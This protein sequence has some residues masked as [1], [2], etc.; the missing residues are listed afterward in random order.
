MRFQRI[1][2][3]SF[4]ALLFTA[5]LS[6][7]GRAETIY[8][9]QTTSSNGDT[10]TG[11]VRF[12]SA[13]PGTITT[14]GPMTTGLVAGHTVRSIDFRP[15]NGL[16]YA[17]SSNGTACQLYSVSTTTSQLF[18]IGGGFTLPFADPNNRVEIDFN[19]VID[20]IRLLTAANLDGSSNPVVNNFTLNPNTGVLTNQTPLNYVPGD[21]NAGL[22]NMELAAAAYTNP[23]SGTTTL[24]GWDWS[25]DSIV[26]IGSIGGTPDSP[27]TGRMTTVRNGGFLTNGR[28]IG[29]DYGP[30]GTLYITKDNAANTNMGLYTYVPETGLG[31]NPVLVGNYGIFISDISV[32]RPPTAA[33]VTLSGRV[34]QGPEGRGIANV[35]VTITGPN[36]F[37]S[38]TTTGKGGRYSF[39]DLETG[40]SYVISIRSRNYN[41]SPRVVQ[42][43]DNISDVD[44][45]VG[46]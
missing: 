8:G 42:V 39:E 30:S 32:Q 43:V 24:Y 38:T 14:I 5:V 35:F 6:I 4:G 31:V 36:G 23:S 34:A 29:M 22:A 21:P 15:S 33:G 45:F 11:L 28:G 1:L 7:N 2:L 18:P 26:R 17:V 10:V 20:T 40:Q 9:I 13:T 44:F 25:V 37:A 41:F 12:D 46:Q 19:P 27:N 16:L 3:A